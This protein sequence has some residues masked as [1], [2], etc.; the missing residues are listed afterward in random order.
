MHLKKDN[1]FMLIPVPNGGGHKRKVS[2]EETSTLFYFTVTVEAVYDHPSPKGSLEYTV[3]SVSGV[4]CF[5]GSR[6]GCRLLTRIYWDVN[7][8]SSFDCPVSW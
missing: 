6:V 2:I 8:L 5:Y 7:S 3:T 1:A 4:S